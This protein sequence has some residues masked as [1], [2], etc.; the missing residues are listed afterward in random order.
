MYTTYYTKLHCLFYAALHTCASYS[1]KVLSG[2][3]VILRAKV[4]ACNSSN[5]L[6][7]INVTSL[8][9]LAESGKQS[10]L[11][12]HTAFF[13]FL[14]IVLVIFL[15]CVFLSST[16][17]DSPVSPS[18]F[19]RSRCFSGER[20]PQGRVRPVLQNVPGRRSEQA[21]SNIRRPGRDR[22]GRP[23]R[24]RLEV[25]QTLSVAY[26]TVS[27]LRPDYERTFLVRNELAAY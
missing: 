15:F 20:V 10:S 7:Y 23:R 13:C 25:S 12:T 5:I 6:L 18:I 11:A 1:Y 14:F 16:N 2:L 22:V 9:R 8:F 3:D 19:P 24:P 26:G 4:A 27:L 17:Y 21:I